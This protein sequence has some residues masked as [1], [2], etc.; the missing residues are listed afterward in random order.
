M[1]K[2]SGVLTQ[3]AGLS[4]GTEVARERDIPQ[5]GDPFLA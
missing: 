5:R 3:I 4:L 2:I 1:T